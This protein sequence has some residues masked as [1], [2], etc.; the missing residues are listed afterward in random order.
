MPFTPVSRVKCVSRVRLAMSSAPS[1]W[2]GVG[3][4]L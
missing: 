1:G 4:M 3:V 2:N